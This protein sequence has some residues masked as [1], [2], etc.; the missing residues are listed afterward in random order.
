MDR[1]I[2]VLSASV[3][4]V[5][6][7]GDPPVPRD[8]QSATVTPEPAGV[9]C[10]SGGV[11]IR[12]GDAEPTYVCNGSAGVSADGGAA[13][14][15]SVTPEAPGPNCPT[16]GVA[17]Q[18]GSAQ[19][20]YVCNGGAG[21]SG[22]GG[23]A[24]VVPEP[25]GANCAA[26]G[27]RFE[28]NGAPPSY[29][30]NGVAGDGGASATVT[31][32]LPGANC[33]TGGVKVQSEGGAATYVCNGAQGDAGVSPTVSPEAP[34]ANC[35][36]G[37]LRVQPESGPAT[38]VCNGVRS[39]VAM[40]TEFAG[41]NCEVGG[42]RIDS[43]PDTNANNVLDPA[44]VTQ[45]RYACDGIG[46]G[47]GFVRT[48]TI[49]PA[50]V[51][52][53]LERTYR[54]NNCTNSIWNRQA[55]V[56]VSGRSCDAPTAR[57]GYWA[58]APDAGYPVDPDNDL[59]QTYSRLVQVPATD[60]VVFTVGANFSGNRG[61]GSGSAANVRVGTLSRT[62]GLITNVQP[63]V[64]SDSYTGNCTLLSSSRTLLLCY[65]GVTTIRRYRT[66]AGSP[67]LT[68]AGT[69]TLA[70][71]LA[72]TAACPANST[73]WCMGGT[74]AFDGAYFYFATHQGGNANK[75]YLVFTPSGAL[76]NT[77]TAAGPGNI[78]GA[79][80][81]WSVGRYSTH[82]VFGVRTGGLQL[83]ASTGSTHV[84]SPVSSQHTLY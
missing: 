1:R 34:G 40:S 11:A 32:E 43:G 22:D 53:S 3:V 9:H 70:I 56:V 4:L 61:A 58:H 72:A 84:F 13:P 52:D 26:G 77:F 71:Q 82:D 8:G 55:D 66:T 37:G 2:F 39:L 28:V 21:P 59:T 19:P 60:T 38:F 80:F 31:T 14:T 62:T 17:I 24:T 47:T 44:E 27:V 57:G 79:Y 5:G 18:L 45:T 50:T 68:A 49:D 73:Q 30:C 81:D 46:V 76:V 23:A 20:S 75:T 78:N 12:V 35:A 33:A 63:A 7:V 6:C 64:F 36:T 41:A 29:V 16:G 10:A 25:A 51:F 42:V 74:F 69:V 83:G 15:V 67:S 48:G 54:Y 65:D